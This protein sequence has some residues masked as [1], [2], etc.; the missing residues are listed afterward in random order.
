MR[1]RKEKYAD[2]NLLLPEY[3]DVA[4]DFSNDVNSKN[5][6]RWEGRG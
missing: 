6:E 5:S 3:T 2:V 4:D 1:R